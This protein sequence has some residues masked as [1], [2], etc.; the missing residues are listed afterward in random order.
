MS[1]IQYRLR[2]D[3][4]K[5]KEPK[6]RTKKVSERRF[7][8]QEHKASHLH[9]DFRLEIKD[10]KTD[11]VVLK[12]W[13]IP[14]NIPTTKEIKHLAIQT[15]DHP[16][17]YLSFEGEIPVGNYGAGTVEIWDKGKWG[18]EKGSLEEGKLSFNLFGEK[19]KGRYAII[20]TKG[21]NSKFK[22]FSRDHL[23]E[24]QEEKNKN[25]ET[26]SDNK[27]WLIWRKGDELF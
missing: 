16:V 12:S 7:V 3:F 24:D 19:L 1:L 10:E 27:Y 20:L 4:K 8:V 5:T 14:K 26:Q 11:K 22:K 6:P 21:L 9:Y 2:R 18:M 15:E 17:D 13:A 23:K 25:K